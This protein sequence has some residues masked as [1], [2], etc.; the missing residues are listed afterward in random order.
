METG[1]AASGTNCGRRN[2]PEARKRPE[3]GQ[4]DAG[5]GAKRPNGRKKQVVR[6]RRSRPGALILEWRLRKEQPL[7]GSERPL[8]ATGSRKKKTAACQEALIREPEKTG[9]GEPRGEAPGTSDCDAQYRA[10]RW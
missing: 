2:G 7:R 4:T 1:K 9:H 8:R 10:C 6:E 5:S 3:A